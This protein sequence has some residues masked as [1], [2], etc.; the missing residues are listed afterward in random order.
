MQTTNSTRSLRAAAS[1]PTRRQVYI[2]IYIY[3]YIKKHVSFS[4]C[5]CFL[6][7]QHHSGSCCAY[8]HIFAT[9]SAVVL[10]Q[11]LVSC[12]LSCVV[13]DLHTYTHTHTHQPTH[14]PTF[15]PTNPP[16][17]PPTHPRTSCQRCTHTIAHA[18]ARAHTH[19]HTGHCLPNCSHIGNSTVLVLLFAFLSSSS[20]SVTLGSI[21]FFFCSVWRRS[22]HLL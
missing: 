6:T 13:K 22:P 11:Y 19:T 5:I 4:A 15:P 1:A 9:Q 14:P 16:S 2:Y 20:P 12:I 10:F 17:H 21:F 18:R 8:S 7:T 3:I